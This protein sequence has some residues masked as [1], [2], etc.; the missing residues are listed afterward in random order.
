M[1]TALAILLLLL[2]IMGFWIIKESNTPNYLKVFAISLFFAFCVIV[3]SSLDSYMGWAASG[4]GLEGK[5]VTIRYVLV[6]EPNLSSGFKGSIYVVLDMPSQKTDATLLN[7]FGHKTEGSEPRLYKIGYSRSLHEQLQSKV[8]P[9]LMKGQSVRG[10]FGKSNKGG[11]DGDGKD[12]DGDSDG[13]GKGGTGKGQGHRGG[14]SDSLEK[15]DMM[16][17]ELPPSYFQP[18]Q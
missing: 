9:R 11:E 10:K 1:F 2:F 3:A 17:Y 12:G 6:K 4:S 5:V 16:F 8:I 13:D 7:V 15:N 18:K 14:G